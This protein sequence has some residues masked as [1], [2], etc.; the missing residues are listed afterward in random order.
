MAKQTTQSE[1]KARGR[2]II[3]PSPTPPFVSNTHQMRLPGVQVK[4]VLV[5]ALC[6]TVGRITAD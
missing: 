5:A 6:N 3:H 1:P 2:N 4:M